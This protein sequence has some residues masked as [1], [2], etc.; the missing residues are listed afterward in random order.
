MNK[1]ENFIISFDRNYL[2]QN[3]IEMADDFSKKKKM[4]Y[5]LKSLEIRS[6]DLF[7]FCLQKF[8]DNEKLKV[9]I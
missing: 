3:I 5:I 8:N 1:I 2:K 6:F 7:F 9:K 4:K